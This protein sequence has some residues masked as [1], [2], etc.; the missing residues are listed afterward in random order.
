MKEPGQK[1]RHFQVGIP[2]Q[3]L[4][5][6]LMMKEK[7]SRNN[8]KKLT[9]IWREFAALPDDY[10]D[11]ITDV[12]TNT[13]EPHS[14]GDHCWDMIFA[15]CLRKPRYG[16]FLFR[17]GD[18]VV[19]GVWV[20]WKKRNHMP[21]KLDTLNPYSDALDATKP[22]LQANDYTQHSVLHDVTNSSRARIIPPPI[23]RVGSRTWTESNHGTREQKRGREW[24]RRGRDGKNEN[25]GDIER[26]LEVGLDRS[27]SSWTMPYHPRNRSVKADRGRRRDSFYRGGP[28]WEPYLD[29]EPDSGEILPPRIPRRA[30]R[31]GDNI[32]R[33]FISPDDTIFSLSGDRRQGRRDFSR[34]RKPPR[35]PDL[36][37]EY[38]WR[39][40]S[41]SRT[42]DLTDLPV[43]IADRG[44]T[45][46]NDAAFRPSRDRR[47]GRQNSSRPRKQTWEPDPDFGSD[48]TAVSRERPT[49]RAD[50]VGEIVDLGFI[51]PNDATSS[52]PR[53]PRDGRGQDKWSLDYHE[54]AV[55]VSRIRS[56]SPVESYAGRRMRG[57]GSENSSEEDGGNTQYLQDN[58]KETDEVVTKRLLGSYTN[59]DANIPVIE[60]LSHRPQPAGMHQDFTIVSEEPSEPSIPTKGDNGD[61]AAK[62]E[63]GNQLA[64]ADSSKESFSADTPA[65]LERAKHVR[66]KAEVDVIPDRAVY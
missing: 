51:S 40:V 55:H 13:E 32:D 12:L 52:L 44:F 45:L 49:R 6:S 30:H 28:P 54:P 1:I 16:G 27:N 53:Y 7:Q 17:K 66:M 14:G 62:T 20:V 18:D 10:R 34:L 46:P 19:L 50:R 25:H 31:G 65:G 64:G 2:Q 47:E 22:L 21:L 4:I 41:P 37:F 56:I 11:A 35:A 60:E 61:T 43:E 3:W 26:E 57:L 42:T 48:W 9:S 15:E 24:N 23:A 29:S 58:R 33:G 39:T 5:E 38:D 8:P 63:G 59:P 36:D